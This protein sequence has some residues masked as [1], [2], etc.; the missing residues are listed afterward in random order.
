M[1]EML[2]GK[3]EVSIMLIYYNL[4]ET[5]YGQPQ[6]FSFVAEAGHVYE[7]DG[8]WHGGDNQIWVTD[9]ETGQVV[10]GMKP[11]PHEEVARL[12]GKS[13]F[14]SPLCAIADLDGKIMSDDFTMEAEMLPG[15]HEVTIKLVEPFM[16]PIWRFSF[17]AE[18]GHVYQVEAYWKTEGLR[19][20]GNQMWIWIVDK[21]TGEVVAGERP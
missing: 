4:Y 16:P 19:V 9:K 8:N 2:P 1:V 3:H 13:L 15:K 21:E 11:L 17:V 10:A 14:L 20:V 7:A 12:K 18:A 6:T 5:T